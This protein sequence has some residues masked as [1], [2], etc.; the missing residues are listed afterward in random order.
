MAK[1]NDQFDKFRAATLGG[2]SPLSGALSGSDRAG[3]DTPLP[4]PAP[5]RVEKKQSKNATRRL[6]S[7]HIEEDIYRKLGQIKFE[8]G[9]KYDDLYNEAVS[10]LV[11][12]YG[13]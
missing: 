1:K 11:T 8:N 5:A 10:D 13:R 6:V 9:C 3:L 2:G 12:K 4:S 7:F